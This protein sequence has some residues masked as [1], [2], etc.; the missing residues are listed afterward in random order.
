MNEITF[1]KKFK[2]LF[3]TPNGVRYYI[4][5][6]GRFSSKSYSASTAVCA[7]VNNE[8]RKALYSRYTLTSAKDSIIPEFSEKIE[9][10][11]LGN[12]YEPKIDRII[13]PGNREVVFKGLRTSSGNQTAKLKS[14]KGFSIFVLDE[15]EEENDEVSFD[16]INLSIREMGVNNIIVLILNPTTKEHWIYKRFFESK[17][18]QG[19]FNGIKDNVCYIHTTYLD[20][21]NHVPK[22]YLTEIEL[23]KTSNTKKYDHIIM[24]GWLDAAEG[25]V[26]DNWE[27]GDFDDSLPFAYGMDFGFFPDPDVLVK[28]AIDHK[29]K[30]LYV[31]QELR[32][33]NAGTDKLALDIKRVANVSKTIWAD[34]S[35]N[36]LIPD[37]KKRGIDNIKPVSKGAGSVL[38]GIKLM[39][40]F[41]II[42]HPDSSD[43]GAEL[44]NYVW[45]D[46]KS[47][48]PIDAYNHS[49]DA[50]RYFVL[51]TIKP[52]FNRGQRAL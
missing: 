4:I 15:A 26:F 7:K 30:L 39:Q 2:P 43:I 31:K 12:W 44:N 45:S 29:R 27:Y 14:L 23:L 16:R 3:D 1:S 37:L 6:G 8:N 10:L 50:I 32:I 19:G 22:D 33:N 11:G 40:D 18:V 9:L 49:I 46:K 41:R 47:G 20:V 13:G 24:G 25:V 38:A 42:V 36:R 34:S 48:I 17:G 51:S 5:T 35:E 52:T 21:I 28:C